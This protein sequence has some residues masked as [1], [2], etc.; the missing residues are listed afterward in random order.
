MLFRSQVP[1]VWSYISDGPYREFSFDDKKISFRHRAN[2]N[3]SGM[4]PIT[5]TVI[6][7]LKSLGKERVN[8]K[9]LNTLKRELSEED[10]HIVFRESSSSADWIRSV[11][12]EVYAS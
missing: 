8:D 10:K 1:M 7:A 2:R 4:S 6:E 11:I 9:V 3:I 12:K 5:V